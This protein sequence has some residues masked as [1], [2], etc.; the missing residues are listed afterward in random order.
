M[1]LSICIT[2]RGRGEL[3]RETLSALR[4]QLPSGGVEIVVT[5]DPTG[6]NT[7]EVVEAERN[8]GTQLTYAIHTGPGGLDGGY[9]AAVGLA[10]GE[11]IWFMSD[12][13][14]PVEGAVER[15]LQAISTQPALVV[16]DRE[17]WDKDF[18][19]RL[20]TRDLDGREARYLPGEEARALQELGHHLQFIP[21][22]VIRRD[23]WMASDRT[24]YLGSFFCH[25]G[26]IFQKPFPGPVVRLAE[27]LVRMRGGN[28]SYGARFIEVW[29][30]RWPDLVWSF[31]HLPAEARRRVTSKCPLSLP[32]PLLFFRAVG[33]LDMK[34]W[35]RQRTASP[36]TTPL[37][38]V[39]GCIVPLRVAQTSMYL[40]QLLLLP[41]PR[42]ALYILE[43][44][45]AWN[46]GSWLNRWLLRLASA[47]CR[48]L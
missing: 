17:S 24:P 46:A 26:V 19:R 23:W 40:I 28:I 42:F 37:I 32:G 41:D 20:K 34:I 27:P 3:L 13:D 29:T 2:T 44:S 35:K 5:E 21:A 12:D 47:R 43:S 36:Q 22:V 33:A 15:I 45:A 6:D 4:C 14:L 9:D 25:V 16:L 39:W 8:L 7:P 11:Y 18:H 48:A 10:R 30:Q 1:R 31:E 38:S